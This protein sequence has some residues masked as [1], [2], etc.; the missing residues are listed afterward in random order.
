V[1]RYI[2][3]YL[4]LRENIFYYEGQTKYKMPS[5]CGLDFQDGNKAHLPDIFLTGR[6]NRIA[7]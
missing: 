2:N 1:T 6:S 4:L 5:D 3:K 7:M